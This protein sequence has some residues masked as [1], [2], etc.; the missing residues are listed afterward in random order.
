MVLWLG[1]TALLHIF[2]HRDA[3]ET[4]D[5][6]VL[7][8]HNVPNSLQYTL[9]LLTGDYPLVDFTLPAKVGG[10]GL[11]RPPLRRFFCR[12]RK[13][14]VEPAAVELVCCPVEVTPPPPRSGP[15][16]PSPRHVV[17]G[18]HFLSCRALSNNSGYQGPLWGLMQRKAYNGAVHGQNRF[19]GNRIE[20]RLGLK[21][22]PRDPPA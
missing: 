8:F 5:D 7:R 3:A 9:I 11:W 17:E 22:G 2:E 12:I 6:G 21:M 14:H 18:K 15:A 16:C 13:P 19:R 20:R 4:D 10:P 1:F